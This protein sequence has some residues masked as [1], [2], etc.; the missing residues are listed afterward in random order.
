MIAQIKLALL[1]GIVGLPAALGYLYGAVAWSRRIDTLLQAG[2]IDSNGDIV[3]E[4]RERLDSP[5]DQLDAALADVL[6][7]RR[8]AGAEER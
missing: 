3:D 2:D 8:I 5:S 7:I 1:A 4:L 6:R